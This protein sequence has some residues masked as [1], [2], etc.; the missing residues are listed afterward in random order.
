MV[1]FD[2]EPASFRVGALISLTSLV[3]LIVP[4]FGRRVWR[5]ESPTAEGH[6]I[7]PNIGSTAI[8]E[9]AARSLQPAQAPVY[10][11]FGANRGRNSIV[12]RLDDLDVVISSRK[13]KIFASIPQLSLHAKGENVDAALAALDAKKKELAAELEEAGELDT[14]E[15]GDQ[16]YP[17]RRGVTMTAPGGLGQFAIKTGIVVFAIAVAFLISGMLI[18]SKVEDL[19]N[20]IKSVKIGGAQ[21]WGRVEQQLDR[22][23]SS[24]LPEAKKQ[25]LLADIHAIA[26]KWRPFVVEVQSV[27]SGPP[28]QAPPTTTPTNR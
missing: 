12:S 23:A 18:A 27:L 13:G 3:A 26:V 10:D 4:L 24:D 11:S 7:A 15:I 17:V 16:V 8:I 22:M 25:K 21:F 1:E 28:N 20:E 6:E 9:P 5:H 19:V 2:Y 14:L